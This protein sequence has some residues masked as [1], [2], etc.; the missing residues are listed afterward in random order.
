LLQVKETK[1]K[2]K[3]LEKDAKLF[4]PINKSWRDFCLFLICLTLKSEQTREVTE[5]HFDQRDLKYEV[6]QI[7]LDMVRRK[8]P[9][10]I[11]G[12]S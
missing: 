12:W 10:I 11:W 9:Q 4:K 6:A 7:L 5:S 8:D 2:K 3:H 1:D